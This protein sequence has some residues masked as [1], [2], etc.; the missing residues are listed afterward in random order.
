M[1]ILLANGLY[2]REEAKISRLLIAFLVQYSIDFEKP[3]LSE[4]E[5]L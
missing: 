3:I 1:N 5:L 4:L 2:L